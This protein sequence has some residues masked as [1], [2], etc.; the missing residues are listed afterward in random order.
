MIMLHAI[1]SS[2]M[3][4]KKCTPFCT[5]LGPHYQS[6]DWPPTIWT[7]LKP[8]RILLLKKN[9][10][11]RYIRF[12]MNLTVCTNWADLRCDFEKYM[13]WLFWCC[14]QDRKRQVEFLKMERQ[15]ERQQVVLRRK[16]EQAAA[17]NKRLKDALTKQQT[18]AE[19]RAKAQERQAGGTMA[20]RMKVIIWMMKHFVTLL[21]GM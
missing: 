21:W 14:L 11:Y 15:H 12:I 2:N 17:A 7:H 1:A 4:V 18:A 20:E 5:R 9:H 16:A 10:H 19:D 3:H 6:N 13:T 8:S